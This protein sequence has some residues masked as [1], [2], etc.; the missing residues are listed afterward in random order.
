MKLNIQTN[1]VVRV[2]AILMFLLVWIGAEGQT[3][4]ATLAGVV[5]D[6]TGAVVPQVKLTL[7]NTVKGTVRVASTDTDGRYSFTSVEPGTYELRGESAG[8]RTEIKSGV[9]L[10]VGGSSE[11]D[12]ALQVGPTSEVVTVTG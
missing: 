12:I 10:A 2:M 11:V 6:P 8:F 1:W 3:T 4:T 7:R 9:V 5:R